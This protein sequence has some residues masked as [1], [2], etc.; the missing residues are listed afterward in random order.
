MFYN[1]F[2]NPQNNSLIDLEKYKKI[3]KV[4]DEILL[5]PDANEVTVAIP[6]LHVIRE[7]PV[8]LKQYQSVFDNNQIKKN[9]IKLKRIIIAKGIDNHK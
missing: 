6:I 4:C 8:F 2:D 7:H 9:K 5:S 3:C 1:D